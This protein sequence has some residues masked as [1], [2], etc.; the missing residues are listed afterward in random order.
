MFTILGN[1]KCGEKALTFLNKPIKMIQPDK[2]AIIYLRH[3][4][5]DYSK[6]EK[7]SLARA[8]IFSQSRRLM[9]LC[10]RGYSLIPHTN[11]L[12]AWINLMD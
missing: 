12:H 7:P 8:I 3:S 2:P 11:F 9:G 6:F 10:L 5:A 4:K 1:V